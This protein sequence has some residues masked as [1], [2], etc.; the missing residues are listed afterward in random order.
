MERHIVHR[1]DP[2]FKSQQ[3]AH[4]S[5]SGSS[6]VVD[7]GLGGG[8]RRGAAFAAGLDEAVDAV[9]EQGD[10]DEE[11]D[12]DDGD[13]VVFLHGCGV[14]AAGGEVGDQ[15]LRLVVVDW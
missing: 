8:A 7:Q 2:M 13:G 4:G 3:H 11:D 5:G 14:D 15:V 6:V 12:D 9:G 1:Q 10:D